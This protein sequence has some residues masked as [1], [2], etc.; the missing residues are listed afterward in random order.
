MC[1]SCVFPIRNFKALQMTPLF[2]RLAKQ[3]DLLMAAA[4]VNAATEVTSNARV[5]GQRQRAPRAAVYL[6]VVAFG[7]SRRLVARVCGLSP[8]AVAKAC[9]DA[10]AARDK[11][12]VDRKFDEL[13]LELLSCR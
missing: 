9:R 8:E 1:V 13:E 2:K 12:D 11:P 6:A 4:A 3:A 5:I 7:Q 10:E